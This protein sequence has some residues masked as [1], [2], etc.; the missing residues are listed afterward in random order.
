MPQRNLLICR[1][2]GKGRVILILLG[3]SLFLCP[4]LPLPDRFHFWH[5]GK[6]D[7]TF[8]TDTDGKINRILSVR[9]KRISLFVNMEIPIYKSQFSGK[10]DRFGSPAGLAF[11]LPFGIIFGIL[12]GQKGYEY[13]TFTCWKCDEKVCW[14]F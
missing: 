14:V 5:S 1:S 12:A 6:A 4:G 10:T 2:Q 3:K 7:K 11:R 8:H 9:L 13:K